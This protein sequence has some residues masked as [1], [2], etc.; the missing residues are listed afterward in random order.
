MKFDFGPFVVNALI[1]DVVDLF[2]NRIKME[3]VLR[4]LEMEPFFRRVQGERVQLQQVLLNLITNALDAM[5]KNLAILMIRSHVQTPDK[6]TVSV[7]DSGPGNDESMKE[8]A[9]KSFVTTKRDRAGDG[10]FDLQVDH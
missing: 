2:Q 7:S 4:R 5:R 1:D 9:F 8:T 3:N 6:V 10:A